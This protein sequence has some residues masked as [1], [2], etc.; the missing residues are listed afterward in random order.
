M[1]EPVIINLPSLPSLP[2]PSL[3]FPPF[4]LATELMMRPCKICWDGRYVPQYPFNQSCPIQSHQFEVRY[5]S[6]NAIVSNDL[7]E[8]LLSTFPHG[9]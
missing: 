5:H 6:S 9:I 7:V 1:Y 4:P 8:E 2:F 3:P